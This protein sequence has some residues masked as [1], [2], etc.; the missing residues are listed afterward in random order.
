MS[1]RWPH[2]SLDFY[3]QTLYLQKYANHNLL[4]QRSQ[5]KQRISTAI[6]SRIVSFEDRWLRIAKPGRA[7]TLL[8]IQNLHL[9]SPNL[10]VMMPGNKLLE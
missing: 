5:T 9:R 7:Q 3:P 4:S 1:T 6:F 10:A 2:C 8:S